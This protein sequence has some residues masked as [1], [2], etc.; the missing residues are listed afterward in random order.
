ME[1]QA[2]RRLQS[3][4]RDKMAFGFE[5]HMSRVLSAGPADHVATLCQGRAPHAELCM[6]RLWLEAYL[7]IH[8]S[9]HI[10]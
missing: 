2:G 1:Q 9:I 5:E 4:L 6:H 10:P 8:R 7:G 3:A